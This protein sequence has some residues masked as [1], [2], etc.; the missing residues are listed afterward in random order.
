[1]I[2]QHD[3]NAVVP[4]TRALKERRETPQTRVE[5][6]DLGS[7][8]LEEAG[9]FFACGHGC[10][11][12]IADVEIERPRVREHGPGIVPMRSELAFKLFERATDR[13]AHLRDAAI[14]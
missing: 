3:H 8:R 4:N 6:P 7:V 9:I 10:K 1:M 13:V 5:A 11:A 12:C 14:E 2:R